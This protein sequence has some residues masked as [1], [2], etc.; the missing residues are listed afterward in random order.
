MYL[1]YLLVLLIPMLALRKRKE[2]DENILDAKS[3]TCIKGVLCLYVLLHNLGLD[4]RTLTP[5]K[6]S[7]CDNTGGIGV[8]LFFFLSAFGIIRSYQVKG[9]G[10]F[11]K[12]L[13]VHIPRLYLISVGVNLLTY[14]VFF[15]GQLETAD[16]LLK[17]FNLDVFNNFK[18]MNRHGWYVTTINGMYLIFMLVYFLCSKLKTEKKFI[19][20]ACI[21]SFLA[22]GFRVGT[23]IVGRGGLYTREMPTFAIGCMYATFYDKVNEWAKKYFLVGMIIAV[24]CIPVGLLVWEPLGSYMS[25]VIIILMSQKFTYYSPITHFLGKIC[26]GVYLFLHFSTLAFGLGTPYMD[27]YND[28]WWVLLNAGFILELSLL[29]YVVE[30][31]ITRAIG[32][33]TDR[34]RLLLNRRKQPAQNVEIE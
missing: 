34:A 24:A 3:T 15:K 1:F 33:G 11:K 19:I 14:V 5:L 27:M 2:G 21:M 28:Y 17:I 29:L 10:Y 31:G 32:W 22:I 25:A 18:P 8:G 20:A 30:R 6:E 7:I 12:L 13:F 4:L 23:S 26:I 16:M 9:N